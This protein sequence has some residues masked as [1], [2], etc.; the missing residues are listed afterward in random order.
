M[1]PFIFVHIYPAPYGHSGEE[2]IN[3]ELTHTNICFDITHTN[4]CLDIYKI[5]KEKNERRES[6]EEI[7]K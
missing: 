3:F 5:L 6:K 1:A 2:L 7:H 4:I